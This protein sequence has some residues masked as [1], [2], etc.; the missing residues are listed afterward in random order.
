MPI[1][2]V[3]IAEKTYRNIDKTE[4]SDL[5]FELLD[6]YLSESGATKKRPGTSLA[7]DLGLG[8]N[9]IIDGLFWW[10]HKSK[11]VA[12][13]DGKVYFISYSGGAFSSSTVATSDTLA[14]NSPVSFATNGTYLFMANG[15]R[16]VY[17]DSSTTTAY[18]ADGDA[19]TTCTHVAFLD[20]YLL[21]NKTGENRCY[22]SNLDAPLTWTAGDYFSAAG[23]ADHIKAIY[24]INR[25]IYL[26]GN[27]SLEIWE[28]DGENPFS[29][30]T[31]GFI[32]MGVIAPNSIINADNTLFWFTNNRYLAKYDGRGYPERISTPYDKEIQSFET[33]SDCRSTYMVIDGKDFLIFSFVSEGRT[34]VYNI[35][36]DDWCEWRYLNQTTQAF[37]RWIGNCYSYAPAWGMS[38]VGSR[39]DSK[40]LLQSS[41]YLTDSGSEICLT[42][43]TGHISYGS[44]NKKK[45]KVL[46][47]IAKRGTGQLT[48]RTPVLMLQW[49]D[50]NQGFGAEHEISLGDAGQ[51][52]IIKRIIRTGIYRTRQY[53]FKITDPVDSI[54]LS[55]E[56]D[57]EVLSS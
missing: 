26:Y 3:P 35:Q 1:V 38:I 56:E 7:I 4:L 53:R 46:R 31:S 40:L 55:A 54:F 29:R 27:V 12:V 14:T 13:S 57:I 34:L 48:S 36:A 43:T 39:I 30:I 45:S 6:G 16:I 5:N 19:P 44:L 21:A 23:D 17:T 52:E 10:E 42:R 20:G 51:T 33:I 8:S 47:L 18:I 25:Q 2:K 11:L 37:E 9:K 49:N 41:D 15:G 24:V 22:Y 50:N 32:Q 28:N